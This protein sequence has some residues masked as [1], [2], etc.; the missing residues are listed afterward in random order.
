VWQTASLDEGTS[1]Q[2]ADDNGS[3]RRRKVAAGLRYPFD[4]Y[5]TTVCVPAATTPARCDRH[6]RS[7]WRARRTCAGHTRRSAP[8]SLKRRKKSRQT[9]ARV[10]RLPARARGRGRTRTMPAALIL[11]HAVDAVPAIVLGARGY[12]GTRSVRRLHHR[13]RVQARARA[14]AG[15]AGA[16]RRSAI[17]SALVSWRKMR[18]IPTLSVGL[19]LCYDTTRFPSAYASCCVVGVPNIAPSHSRSAAPKHVPIIEPEGGSGAP[20]ISR[21]LCRASGYHLFE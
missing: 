21:I 5:R 17:R 6:W 1:R 9:T 16:A 13:Q 7:R 18:S 2:H 15:A 4:V 3:A 8:V 20:K 19:H 10:L 12:A 14:T 11:P